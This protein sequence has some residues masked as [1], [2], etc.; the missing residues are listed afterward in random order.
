MT[1]AK[2]NDT[3]ILYSWKYNPI[4][5][6]DFF[7]DSA[8]IE[9]NPIWQRPN[10]SNIA[11]SVKAVPSKQQ[12]I[13]ESIIE[14]IDIGEIKLCWYQG[15]KSS[16]DGGNRKR[17]ILDF[18]NNKF[19]LHKSNQFGAKIFRDL[20]QEVKDAI[21][22]YELRFIQ[23]GE[24]T[25]ELI[26]KMFRSTNNTTHVNHQEM[27]NSYGM[28]LIAC[29]VREMVREFDEI[30]NTKHPLFKCEAK[31]NGD[32]EYE[33]LAFDN[34]R[35]FLEEIVAR[36]LCRVV[37]G[38]SFG[39][40]S[41]EMLEKMYVEQGAACENDPKLLETYKKKLTAALDFL[42]NVAKHA[43]NIRGKGI[44]KRQTSMLIRLYFHFKGKYGDF[45]VP[46][47]D[48]FWKSFSNAFS[49][50]DSKNPTRKET[51]REGVSGTGKIRVVSEAFNGYMSFDLDNA[52]KVKQ[53]LIWMLE[54]FEPLEV[55]TPVD[56]KRCFTREEIEQALIEQKFLCYV[57]GRP[58]TMKDAAGAHKK[59]WSKGG[60]TVRN[61]LVAV[62][63]IHN[64]QSGSMDIDTYK[65]AMKF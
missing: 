35:L 48:A 22:N 55:I 36:I 37:Y 23:Y 44:T 5:I 21:M 18:L 25:D 27:L 43:R 12:S 24:L 15:V 49:K 62:R 64:K 47:Y 4:T 17:A 53:S 33:F 6:R 28:N 10:V 9:C 42:L 46:C 30:G 13:I 8:N 56:P 58:L 65:S 41:D 2:L 54:E 59:A 32:I 29:L 51:F 50:F 1:T 11:E 57:D 52:W 60:K 31:K 20:P 26:G 19:P 63:T 39:I 61:N 7:L 38:E 16:I 34:K 40:A 45:R 3:S 14:G